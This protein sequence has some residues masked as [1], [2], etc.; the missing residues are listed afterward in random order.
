MIA[1]QSGQAVVWSGIV[2]NAGLPPTKR[3]TP[4]FGMGAV[5]GG[6]AAI[7]SARRAARPSSGNKPEEADEWEEDRHGQAEREQRPPLPPLPG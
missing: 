7:L 2:D 3:P 4:C 6:A 5:S 1:P